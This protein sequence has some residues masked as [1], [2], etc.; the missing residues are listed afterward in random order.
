MRAARDLIGG[1]TPSA[2]RSPKLG[3]FKA[4]RRPRIL[5]FYRRCSPPARAVGVHVPQADVV[6]ELGGEDAKIVF[7]TGQLE[8]GHERL[9]RG[10]HRRFYRPDGGPAGRNAVR[11]DE[12]AQGAELSTPSRPAAAYSPSRIFSRCST[13]ARAKEDVAASILRR[14]STRP[15][16]VWRRAAGQRAM[17][18][19]SAARFVLLQGPPERFQETLKLDDA[20]AHFQLSRRMP[21]RR[22]RQSTQAARRR[23]PRSI[24][25]SR[26]SKRRTLRSL[27]TTCRRCSRMSSGTG[28]QNRHAMHDVM[29]QNV[30]MYEGDA[31][32]GIDCGST[33]TKLVAHR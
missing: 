19:S 32:L 2:V 11:A 17:C 8:G 5:I 20:H 29:T 28:I 23:P 4:W 21:S 9:L 3:R 18:C 1:D 22:A 16:P 14:S 31:Y 25:C 10:R 27:P 13:R 33:T 15:L 7:L 6:I 30:T 12:L 26:R 24:R